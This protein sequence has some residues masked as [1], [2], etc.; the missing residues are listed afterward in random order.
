MSDDRPLALRDRLDDLNAKATAWAASHPSP[1]EEYAL[2]GR[3][4]E[5]FKAAWAVW[6]SPDPEQ[7][8]SLLKEWAKQSAESFY[9]DDFQSP[10]GTRMMDLADAL[11]RAGAAFRE[12]FPFGTTPREGGAR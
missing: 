5:N 10:A 6:E 9:E 2:S 1:W 4:E 12:A 7:V 11:E 8:M 3:S